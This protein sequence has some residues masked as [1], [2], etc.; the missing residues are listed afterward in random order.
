MKC[1]GPWPRT[2]LFYTLYYIKNHNSGKLSNSTVVKI[3]TVSSKIILCSISAR[4][5]DQ[6]TLLGPAERR[7]S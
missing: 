6:N 3:K 2:D 7:K 4:Y 5:F 1:P